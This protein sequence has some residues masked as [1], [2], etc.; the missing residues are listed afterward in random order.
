MPTTRG[1]LTDSP[2]LPVVNEKSV[3]DQ[4]DIKLSGTPTGIVSVKT[5]GAVRAVTQRGRHQMNERRLSTALT[6]LAISIFASAVVLESER[7]PNSIRTTVVPAPTDFQSATATQMDT[8]RRFRGTC[9][10]EEALYPD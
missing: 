9:Y 1:R 2:P 8:K 7:P 3:N 10:D 4:A 5:A 6:I